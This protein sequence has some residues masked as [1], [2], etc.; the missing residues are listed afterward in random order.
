MSDP[1]KA[2]PGH[3]RVGVIGARGRMGA[4]TCQAVQDAGDLELVAEV[5]GRASLT[6]LVEAGV[7]VAVEFTHPDVVMD[8]LRFCL[9]NGIDV[10]TGT[11]GLLGPRLEVVRGWLADH[12]E[13]SVVV[14]PNFAVGAVLTARFARQAARFFE[15]VEVIERHHAGKIDAPSFT[16]ISAAR[17]IARA[18]ADAGLGPVPDATTSDPDG[19]RGA[20]VD[21]IAV[22]AVRMP[23]MVAHLEVVLGSSGE[24]LTLRH[25]S[26][27]RS[28]FM[29]GVLL[30]VRATTRRP[31]LTV[32]LESLL[33]LD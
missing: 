26:L 10:V 9:E 14:A 19:A 22:H 33:E 16:A 17:E 11:S 25:D 2:V 27:H 6:P 4:Q 20:D 1:S 23:G 21:G 24:T 31:G 30:A 29:P 28:S 15:S 8:N 13:R 3:L 18:R 7:Q 5:G 32:G 12:P